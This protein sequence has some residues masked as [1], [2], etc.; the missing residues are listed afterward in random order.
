VHMLSNAQGE[1]LRRWL[2]ISRT[3]IFTAVITPCLIGAAVAFADG[4]FPLLSFA[5]LILGLVLAETMNLLLSDWV[6]YKQID[7]S[8]GRTIPPPHL[9]GNPMFPTT[10]LPLKNTVHAGFAVAVPALVIL[11]Y[12]ASN[13]GWPILVFLVLAA[14]AGALYVAPPFRYAFFSTAFI[15]PIVAFGTYF[16]L[17]GMPGWKAGLSA[18]PVLFISSGVIYTYRVLYE[19][20]VQGLFEVK[21]NYLKILYGLC[22]LALV[23]LVISSA[24]TPWILLGMLGLPLCIYTIR[25]T[26]IEKSDYMPA[27]SLGVLLH[28]STGIFISTGYLLSAF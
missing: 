28:F 4:F 14:I 5:L 15:P 6:E 23:V 11:L 19:S 20:K 3:R 25:L 10:I 26:S 1:L 22:Y 12:F 8:K 21:R 17:S 27:T 13:L 7:F 9:E 24:A 2:G 18:L 16:V